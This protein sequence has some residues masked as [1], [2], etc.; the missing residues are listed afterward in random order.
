MSKYFYVDTSELEIV[1][2][3]P[4]DGF[5]VL[6]GMFRHGQKKREESFVDRSSEYVV[7]TREEANAMLKPHVERWLALMQRDAA[8]HARRSK[9][10][11]RWVKV[12]KKM[13]AKL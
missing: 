4:V 3:K 8:A 6:R 10:C 1:P 11:K 2:L 13:L 12:A 7:Q 9:D 5:G